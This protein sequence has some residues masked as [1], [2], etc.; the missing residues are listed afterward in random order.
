MGLGLTISKMIIQQMG[1]EVN[2]TSELNK[3]SKFS[4]TAP[5]GEFGFTPLA[6]FENRNESQFEN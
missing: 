3:G 5:L 4:F 6:Q 1:G 2:V